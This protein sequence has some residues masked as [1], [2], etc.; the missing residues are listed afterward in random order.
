[1]ANMLDNNK[2][3]HGD[4]FPASVSVGVDAPAAAAIENAEEAAASSPAN[5]T[6][7]SEVPL[8]GG[9]AKD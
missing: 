9:A 4:Q 5:E 1:M 8:V 2:K 7:V 3:R 6:T